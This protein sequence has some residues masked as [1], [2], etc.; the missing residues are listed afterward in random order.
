MSQIPNPTR[1]QRR[2]TQRLNQILG[3]AARLFAS[4]GFHR[5]TTRE[6]AEAA[7]VSEGTLYN[8][9]DSKNDLLIA[10]IARLAEDQP[11]EV[12]TT[13][14]VEQGARQ[15]LDTLLHITKGSVEEHALMQ[16]AVLSEILA[17][18]NLRQRY[19]QQVMEPTLNA[20][21]KQLKLRIA[22]GQIRPLEPTLTARVFAGLALGLFFL[23]VLGDP[24]IAADWDGIAKAADTI[25]FDG[26]GP[27]AQRFE[28]ERQ[29]PVD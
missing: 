7:D 22:L 23:Q 8:Y 19:Y 10:I 4:K 16:Q 28:P 12:E 2:I 3:A 14:D 9:F 17:D 24:P 13:G 20:L 6:I 29:T 27:Q 21:E 26:L 11:L 15:L 18:E 5:T 25:V 1:R